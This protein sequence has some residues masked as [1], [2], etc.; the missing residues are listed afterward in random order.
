MLLQRVAYMH[1]PNY[2]TNGS[3]PTGAWLT[4]CI[5]EAAAISRL[6]QLSEIPLYRML[7]CNVTAAKQ[8]SSLLLDNK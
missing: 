5:M 1:N 6:M 8:Y 7:M 4:N 3:C 2:R